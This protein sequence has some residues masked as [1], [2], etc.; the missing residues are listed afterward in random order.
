M[1][2]YSPGVGIKKPMNMIENPVYPDIKQGPPRFVWSKKHWK[3][4]AG[5]TLRDL[6]AQTSLYD[7]AVLAQSS[8]YNKT[9][10]GQSSHRDIVNAEFRPPIQSPYE[11]FH[12]LS[13]TPATIHA[14]Q[15]R[16]N[17]GTANDTGGTNGFSAR[18]ERPSNIEANI[19]D[20]LKDANG[21]RPTYYA[22]I[23]NPEDNSVLPDLEIKL[24][25]VSAQSGWNIPFEKLP[26][27][28]IINLKQKIFLKDHAGYQSQFNYDGK[29]TLESFE[30]KRN[31]PIT[32]VTSGTTTN[33]QHTDFS[34]FEN[35]EFN[36][37]TPFYSLDSGKTTTFTTNND[38]RHYEFKKNTPYISVDSGKNTFVMLDGEN[39]NN[40]YDL[41]Y[42]IQ[43]YSMDSGKNT[44]VTFFEQQ[45][46]EELNL[47]YNK[48]Q[49]SVDSGKNTFVMLDA[50]VDLP[51]LKQ[52]RT[53]VPINTNPGSSGITTENDRDMNSNKYIRDKPAISY[54][55]PQETSFRD[56]NSRNIRPHFREKLQAKQTHNFSYGSAMPMKMNDEFAN[57][58]IHSL[59]STQKKTIV[60]KMG[61]GKKST[62]YKF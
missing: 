51:E 14:I 38:E 54:Y 22:P 6:E 18:N 5:A 33:F 28:P 17:P 61:Y 42:K 50:A 12:A 29:S 10:Y 20:R 7:H 4:D 57:Q 44:N 3:V 56:L 24:P 53:A 23:E 59:Q 37:K 58:P 2:H 34:R 31:M 9:V 21:W 36:P 62:Q 30:T 26:E 16:I 40:H 49:V 13:R 39:N 15:P 55:I 41:E 19:T 35:F 8:D 46:P 11:D 47:K 60:E 32:P 27:E 25:P 1:T 48:P 52:Q 43:P 45:L